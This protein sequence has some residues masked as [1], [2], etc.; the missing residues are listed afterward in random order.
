MKAIIDEEKH[1]QVQLK[2]FG[3]DNI[4]HKCKK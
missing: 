3:R 1:A 4:N 2:E